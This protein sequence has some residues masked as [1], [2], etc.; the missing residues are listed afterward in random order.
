M[1]CKRCETNLIRLVDDNKI[2]NGLKHLGIPYMGHW[3]CPNCYPKR[4][5][6]KLIKP[7]R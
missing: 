6:E 5:P 4:I 7:K 2:K 3:I 1:R